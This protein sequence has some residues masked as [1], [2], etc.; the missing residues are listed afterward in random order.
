MES[1]F[2]NHREDQTTIDII[3][4]SSGLSSP[5]YPSA[6]DDICYPVVPASRLPLDSRCPTDVDL[7]AL[8][9]IIH[10]DTEKAAIGLIHRRSLYGDP[11]ESERWQNND[12][13]ET[14]QCA[15]YH[16]D[17]GLI[18]G[19]SLLELEGGKGL[20]S[21]LTKENYWIDITCPSQGDMKTLAKVFRIHPLTTEDIM[22]QESRE[23]CDVFRNYMFVCYR[24][25]VQ[26]KGQLR[27]LSFYHI[28]FRRSIVTIHFVR[29]PHMNS[30]YQ[31]IVQLQDHL[32]TVPDWINYAVMDE[33]TDSF[34]PVIQQIEAEVN[35]IE[36]VVLDSVL[37]ANV[38]ADMVNRIGDCRKHVMQLLR[39]LGTKADVLRTLIK[40]CETIRSAEDIYN[41]SWASKSS[42]TL[43]GSPALRPLPNNTSMHRRKGSSP[44][45][46]TPL[47]LEEDEGR[48][49]PD[50]GLYLGDV[51][52]HILAMLQNLNH[53]DTVLARSH[54]N[55]LTRISIALTQTSNSTNQV[56]G[57]LTIFATILLPMNLI[58]GLWGMNVKVPGKDHDDLL[59]FGCIVSSLVIFAICSLTLAKQTRLL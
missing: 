28:I 27:P 54:S 37:D 19:R 22:G 34:A 5:L 14:R 50:V 24:G 43:V 56:I 45:Q 4:P 58:T 38:D 35:S 47:F 32:L 20:E 46:V 23:K 39:L 15:Y 12:E 41:S 53:Y 40:R 31:R 11:P 29:G 2:R 9:R 25:C 8:N 52:D 48:M 30:V 3:D 42:Q 1:Y 55:Y 17:T 7:D 16:P 10:Q 33:I 13:D 49:L 57:R 21:L 6:R 26:D 51:Q 44:S 59:Y 18:H 36:E